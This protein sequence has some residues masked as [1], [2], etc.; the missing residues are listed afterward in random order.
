M[1]I[2]ASGQVVGGSPQSKQNRQYI[3]RGGYVEKKYKQVAAPSPCTEPGWQL[4]RHLPASALGWHPAT[5]DLAGTQV[6]GT[7]NN[8]NNAW[9]VRFDDMQ[10]NDKFLVA[11]GDCK[12]WLVAT[13]D[14]AIGT[15]YANQR[16]QILRSSSNNSPYQAKWYNRGVGE[17]PWL[18]VRDHGAPNLADHQ[19]LYGEGGVKLYMQVPVAHGGANVYIKREAKKVG[20]GIQLKSGTQPCSAGRILSKAECRSRAVLDL[21][22]KLAPGYKKIRFRVAWYKRNVNPGC[23]LYRYRS[24]RRVYFNS[25]TSGKARGNSRYSS[26]CRTSK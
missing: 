7:P 9:S 16:R 26:L 21:V 20:Y 19:M 11:S 17:D 5:D 8:A 24:I 15:K 10:P 12:V 6:Y 4:V 1:L 22:D 14:Q 3:R 2:A 13:K 25:N 23:N 18:S